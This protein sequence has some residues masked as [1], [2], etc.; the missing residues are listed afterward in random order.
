[1]MAVR[2]VSHA[3]V[4]I[5]RHGS[6]VLVVG[7]VDRHRSGVEP[8]LRQEVAWLREDGERNQGWLDDRCRTSF[9]TNCRS[10]KMSMA[11]ARPSR[12]VNASS[13]NG[14]SPSKATTPAAPLI[15]AGR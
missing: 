8:Q 5:A 6:P 12:T 1:Q 2:P 10:L 3:G 13:A 9:G 11:T 7:S 14:C 15:S 4:E